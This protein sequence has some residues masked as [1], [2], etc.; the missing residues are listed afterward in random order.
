MLE[1][2]GRQINGHFD[3]HRNVLTTVSASPTMQ[4]HLRRT[5]VL[6]AVFGISGLVGGCAPSSQTAYPKPVGADQYVRAVKTLETGNDEAA[7]AQLEQAVV[8]NPSLR[9]AR[10][11]LGELFIARKDYER[12]V[13]QLEVAAD[14]DPYTLRNHYNLGLSLQMINRLQESAHAYLRG[15]KV[16]PDDF[17]SNMNLG[18]VYFALNQLDPAIYY[19]EKA[20]RIEPTN[21]RAWSNIGV[22]Y[23]ARGNLTF[24]EA[25]YRKALE[26]DATAESTLINLT[27]NLINQKKG[28]EAVAIARQLVTVN[29]SSLSKKRLGDA[30][31]SAAQWDEA[32][33]AYDSAVAADARFTPAINAK[34]EQ[35]ITHYETD[36]RLDDALR[37]KALATWNESLKV[38]P[39]QPAVKANLAKWADAK[40]FR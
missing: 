11:T 32:I 3:R 19:L 36:L 15:L 16:A 17:K 39:D 9:M 5:T 20:T 33:A 27:S 10:M 24:A 40:V 28:I 25:S 23:D 1:V 21:A 6:A 22:L 26:L 29:G 2:S 13:P 37:Q 34:A 31:T 8:L 18:L 14:L 35:F 30:L 4:S 12:A 38:I 7:I